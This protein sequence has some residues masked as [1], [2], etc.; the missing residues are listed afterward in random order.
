MVKQSMDLL[1]CYAS[2][3]WTD[4]R[5]STVSFPAEALLRRC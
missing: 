4:C 3:V 5:D 2:A 1:D